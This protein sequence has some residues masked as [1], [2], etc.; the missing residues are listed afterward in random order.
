MCYRRDASIL[1]VKDGRV[2]KHFFISTEI[3][4]SLRWFSEQNWKMSA[5]RKR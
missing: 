4:I 1:I 3:H 5:A 2:K